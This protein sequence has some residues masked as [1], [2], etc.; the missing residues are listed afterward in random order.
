MICLAGY[1]ISS[2]LKLLVAAL[3]EAALRGKFRC[4]QLRV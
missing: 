4:E 2:S 3:G 1:A